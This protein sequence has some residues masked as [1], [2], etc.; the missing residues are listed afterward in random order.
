MTA[1]E[2]SIELTGGCLCGSVRYIAEGRPRVHYCHCAMCRKATGS[3]FA[4]LAWVPA[5]TLL[6]RGATARRERRSSPIARRSF[7]PRCGTPLTLAY[8]DRPERLALHAGTLDH[9]GRIA[10]VSHYGIEGRLAWVD[11]GQDLPERPT[12]ERW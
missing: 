6:W 11:C 3:A 10:P 2:T 9:P 12:E 4:V 8:D 1:A 7:C 5:S